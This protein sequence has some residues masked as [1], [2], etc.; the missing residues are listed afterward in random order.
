MKKALASI[1][2]ALIVAL[3]P[4]T[5]FYQAA[6]AEVYTT[7]TKT[8]YKSVVL[9]QPL[10]GS[11]IPKT[12][13]AGLADRRNP[14]VFSAAGR[15]A[16]Q[17]LSREDGKPSLETQAED[18]SV[19]YDQ[20]T[21][22]P[23]ASEVAG[24]GQA[25]VPTPA[26]LLGRKPLKGRR[27]LYLG[28]KKDR[29]FILEDA[30]SYAKATGAELYVVDSL[31]H[32]KDVLK[33]I[34]RSHFLAAD[35]NNHAPKKM[36]IEV[37][38]IARWAK[39]NGFTEDDRVHSSLNPYVELEG[40]LNDR[41]GIVAGNSYE[42]LNTGHSK[43]KAR[44]IWAQDPE[45]DLP[46][47]LI[48]WNPPQNEAEEAANIEK[49]RQAFRRIAAS[50]SSGMVVLKPDHGGASALV[51][52]DLDSEE[53][54]VAGWKAIN[55]GLLVT[56]R[57]DRNFDMLD[58]YPGILMEYQIPKGSIEV[59]IEGVRTAPGRDDIS[60]MFGNA[61]MDPPHAVE[62]NLEIPSQ[63]PEDIQR[64]GF[65]I[66]TKALDLLPNYKVGNS[67][68]EMM[69]SPAD[70]RWYIIEANLR[71]GGAIV[72]PL[73]E[74]LTMIN[75]IHEGLNAKFG[76][77]LSK[78][79]EGFS[80][81]RIEARFV[82]TPVAGTIV[83]IEGMD[84]IGRM[85]GV[86]R[87]DPFKIVGDTIKTAP[88]DSFDYFAMV[89]VR[90]TT[91]EETWKLTQKALRSI[92]YTV[93]TKEGRLVKVRGDYSHR[94]VDIKEALKSP[95]ERGDSNLKESSQAETQQAGAKTS[96]FG[97]L[98]FV[99]KTLPAAFRKFLLGSV[100]LTASSEGTGIF[101]QIYGITQFG[102]FF[103]ILSLGLTRLFA[104]PGSRYAAKLVNRFEPIKVYKLTTFIQGA[105]LIGLFIGA[106]FLVG[107]TPFLVLYLVTQAVNGLIYGATRGM[108]ESTIMPQLVGQDRKELEKAGFVWMIF[109]EGAALLTAFV[110]SPLT[111]VVFGATTTFLI[112]AA[113]QFSSLYYFR[114]VQ[115]AALISAETN[116]APQTSQDVTAPKE[117]AGTLE[118]LPWREYIPYL[119]GSFMHFSFYALFA[120][121]FATYTLK[122]EVHAAFQTGTYDSG[123]FLVSLLAV[124]PAFLALIAAQNKKQQTGTV[125]TQKGSDRLKMWFGLT[126]LSIVG[127]LGAGLFG[128]PA[129]S[130]AMA[131]ILGGLI[132]ISRTKWMA[133]YQ[134]RLKPEK[135]AKMAANL[136][137]LANAMSLI[138]FVIIAIGQLMNIAILPLLTGVV[139][140]VSIAALLGWVLTQEPP[141]SHNPADQNPDN[142][143]KGPKGS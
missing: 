5:G 130:I 101:Y 74:N 42:A 29:R 127:Y 129:L 51:L 140:V 68:V 23:D 106:H 24:G 90:G 137:G 13:T 118:K 26:A 115:P 96:F 12:R 105:M 57:P 62:K 121:T 31:D 122:N 107:T 44:A 30:I 25:T 85:P 47:E 99:W 98:G 84:E 59:D 7:R 93:L 88:E 123:S 4:G 43:S 141:N 108:A 139:A 132:T 138:P 58:H 110:L 39:R 32:K 143:D 27:L 128:I 53:K 22:R 126:A 2:A 103:G 113:I 6:A 75:L 111:L 81:E 136:S 91:Y 72:A 64:E 109:C 83:K 100:L 78:K 119:F 79:Y 67:H 37:E 49:V 36:D 131:A 77:P 20:N 46:H 63:L 135:H 11:A 89:S 66:R 70:K 10:I 114:K 61:D 15:L 73:V 116:Q 82:I 60:I 14:A 87:V 117:E 92:R 21:R 28:S 133:S 18:Q 124:L 40:K 1:L 34:P 17:N 80:K 95:L 41:L 52:T 65:R 71:M 48:N 38:K 35:I 45:T 33:L 102:A 76:L 54:A 50:G 9:H 16:E 120:G 142:Q 69:Y 112:F 134:H 3:A 56:D 125:N 104:I 97:K 55:A 94:P 86:I 8:S 19:E